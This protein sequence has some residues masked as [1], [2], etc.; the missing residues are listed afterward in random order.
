MYIDQSP[1]FHKQVMVLLSS[2]LQKRRTVG[3]LGRDIVILRFCAASTPYADATC[4]A[5]AM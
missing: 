5:F 2:C 4:T 3:G 1:V